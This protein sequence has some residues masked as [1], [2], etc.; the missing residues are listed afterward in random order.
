MS[1]HFHRLSVTDVR[2]ET[3]DCISVAFHLP[4]EVKSDFAFQPGQNI[5]IKTSIGNAEL[6]RSY[7]ICSG[8]HENELRIAVKEAPGGVFSAWANKELV[9]G[10]VLD[11]LPP[12]GRFTVALNPA[13]KKVYLA[14]AAGSGITPVLS[15][16]SAVLNSEPM[17]T[18]TLIYGNRDRASIIFREQ[19]LALKNRYMNRFVMHQVLSREKTET[20]IYSGR[21]TPTKCDDFNTHLIDF[22]SMDDIFLCGPES[23]IFD[24]KAWLLG[25]GVAI[26]KIHYELFTTPL[27]QAASGK[28]VANN[29]NTYLQNS[30]NEALNRIARPQISHVT[31]ILDGNKYQFDLAI[32][33][34]TILGGALDHGA[35]LPFSCKGGVCS[36]CRAK[37]TEGEIEMALNYALEPEE[38][39]AGFILCC[40]A[41]PLTANVVVDFDQK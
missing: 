30:A 21:I 24:I 17:S 12:T 10:H 25:K 37:V 26:N 16:I 34:D 36:T 1:L 31:V 28:S 38:V 2:R 27:T 14:I 20:D 23:M 39:L 22:Q 6:R 19:L 15:I 13:H 32:D 5:T 4:D 40:Q 9:K 18:V 8:P 29:E 35:D 11:V 41:H 7:S 3:A 33:G